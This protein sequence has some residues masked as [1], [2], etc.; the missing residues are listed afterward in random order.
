MK[1]TLLL[2]ALFAIPAAAQN[3]EAGILGGG[4]YYQS[5]S[6]SNPRGDADAGFSTGWGA[7]FI[8]GHNQYEHVG[9]EIR[10]T[11]LHNKMKLSSGNQSADFGAESHSIHYDFLIHSAPR[12]A[13][14]RP[15]VAFG[16]G[17]KQYRG[18][19]TE[20]AFQPLSTIAIL[21]KT[22]EVKAL[23]SVGGGVKI[24]LSPR[25]HLRFDVHDYLTPFP[26]EVITPANGSSVG[27]WVNNIVGMAG[28]GFNF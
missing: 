20:N 15:Y 24:R 18:T 1:N 7:A 13:K 3:Y 2:V 5:K 6:V 8:L 28:I 25:M 14:M 4:S 17:V 26:K 10:Y 19:G 11:Y 23:A 27:G 12:D 22:S 9:G 21:T 16:A